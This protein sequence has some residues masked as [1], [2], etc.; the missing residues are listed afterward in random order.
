MEQLHGIKAG[1]VLP[2][3]NEGRICMKP[4]IQI[5]ATINELY[6]K[7]ARIFSDQIIAAVNKA[8][9]CSIVLSGGKTP[10]P[11]YALL[12]DETCFSRQIP[13][14]KLFFF[15]G[16]ERCVLPSHP[17]SNFKMV[18]ETL[19]A[20]IPVRPEQIFRIEAEQ[21]DPAAAAKSY[22]TKLE[23][24]FRLP[25]GKCPVFDFVILGMGSD[26]HTASLF[27]AAKSTY[28]KED[29]VAA[30]WVDKLQAYRISLL[31]NALN[32]AKFILFLVAGSEKAETLRE[33][34]KGNY[35]PHHLPAQLIRP[36]NG[37]LLW[38]A[39]QAAASLL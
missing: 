24:F 28:D 15:W 36:T 16:D 6:L 9:F 8:G 11:L 12:A 35:Q 26:G 34:L 5:A 22:Q 27:P 18:Y 37:E 10:Q 38:L 25:A 23:N 19:L 39:D 17:N 1:A 29:C 32:N 31:P 21:S 13:W 3:A 7:A 2:P 33:V 14:D 30:F 20:K 4:T